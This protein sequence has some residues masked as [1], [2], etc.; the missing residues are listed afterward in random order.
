MPLG[1]VSIPL[2]HGLLMSW[3]EHPHALLSLCPV[4]MSLPSRLW[5]SLH[6]SPSHY[7][8]HSLTL[9][10][11]ASLYFN[12]TNDILCACASAH[13]HTGTGWL[14]GSTGTNCLFDLTLHIVSVSWHIRAAQ[15]FQIDALWSSYCQAVLV[16]KNV[17]TIDPSGK[18]KV[19]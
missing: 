13:I 3:G 11:C 12:R 16:N 14:I 1:S 5:L 9:R 15:G 2:L 17:F 7:L 4:R 8:F 10:C 6:L 18:I 19:K